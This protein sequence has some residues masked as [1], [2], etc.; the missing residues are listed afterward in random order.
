MY[1]Y[2]IFDLDGTLTDPLEG[3]T[4]S[5]SYS[6][7]EMNIEIPDRKVFQDFIGPPLKDSYE[8]WFHLIG[9]E[10]D[11]AIELYRVYY[12]D[13]GILENR[14]YDG[15]GELLKDLH[16][17]G[18]FLAIASSKPEHFVHRVLQSFDI[19]Q[20]FSVIAGARDDGEGG[21]KIAV[22]TD[23]L[24]RIRQKEGR[25]AL[26]SR[27]LMVGDRKF[28]IQAARELGTD[29]CAVSY[30]Y[31]QMSELVGCDPD[32]IADDLDDL[33]FRI[34]D[35]KPFFRSRERAISKTIK[36]LMPLLIFWIIELGIYNLCYVAVLHFMNPPEDM[37]ERIRVYLN[38]VA[39]IATWPYLAR[40]Y[41]LGKTDPAP[42]VT[43]RKKKILL[44][45]A[46]LLV[47]YSMA[48]SLGLNIIFVI[49]GLTGASE[50]YQRV[51]AGQYS[52]ALPVGLVIY[53]IL[54]P[55]TEEL[56]FR[57]IIQERIARYFPTFLVI[58]LSALIF[59]CYHGNPVQII[60]AFLMG[61]ALAVA[62]QVYGHLA[63]SVIMHCAANLLVYFLSKQVG[64][65]AG[66]PAL[67]FG[68]ILVAIACFISGY[69][70]RRLIAD[71]KRKGY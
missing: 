42:V 37:Q 51:A 39:A 28:D 16:D 50:S 8:K 23:A 45:E 59:G 58:P 40:Q 55:F 11:R 38:V 71:R 70:I 52:V 41:S 65:T 26:N 48:L 25:R 47:A 66:G 15:M 9:E 36:V 21:T 27:I 32:Y 5:V 2:V 62:Y 20:Y 22:L 14:L 57:G 34:T 24:N 56:L 35:E 31:G 12:Q 4:N 64:F 49:W 63:A 1:Q 69:Y 54:T 44:R 3:I 10:N 13:K 29:V 43:E 60:Y 33:R 7:C 6:L 61:L 68:L 46:P 17:R 19:E 18:I 53:G 30:G 67:A